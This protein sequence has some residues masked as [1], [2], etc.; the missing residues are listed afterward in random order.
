MALF[1]FCGAVAAL[2]ILPLASGTYRVGPGRVRLEPRVALHGSTVIALPPLGAVE[3]QTHLSPIRLRLSPETIDL[4]DVQRLLTRRSDPKRLVSRLEGE[5]NRALRDAALRM[6]AVG[7]GGGLLAFALLRGTR[8]GELA[9]SVVAGA[10][11]PIL[12]FAAALAGYHPEAFR[13]PILT[14][15]LTRAPEIVGPVEKIEQRLGAFRKQ[16]DA[17]G[18]SAFGI[19]RFLADQSPVPADAVRILHIS[20][21]HLNPVGFDVALQV[22]R[23][24]EVCAVFD[25][26]DILAQGT[27][28]EA[29][30]VGRIASFQVPYVF[31][32]G[33]HDSRS[34]EAAVAAQPNARVLDGKET[35]IEGLTVAGFGDPLFTPGGTGD[36]SRQ[37]E[38]KMRYAERVGEMIDELETEP[39]LVMVHDRLIAAEL[40]GRS[41]LVLAGHDHRWSNRLEKGT[42]TLVSGST[43][44]AG[45][46]ELT[47]SSDQPIAL[48]VLYFSR[49]TRRLIAWDR[50]E[51]QGP[52]GEFYLKRTTLRQP[53]RP[54][55]SRTGG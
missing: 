11:V 6:A 16:L 39:D 52:R 7:S 28:L 44:A 24:F 5:R 8:T 2:A 41:R 12:V 50:I 49:S 40:L 36:T 53:H 18:S 47:P 22:A 13:D 10:L 34:T 54:I 48:E 33:N 4:P 20:D 1:A 38:E 14:G 19:Y 31:V 26:G 46:H 32:R 15:A 43:G 9:A 17:L 42:R 23:Q 27:D 55:A 30:F 51:V 45:L 21:L 3:A 25:T 37:R 35:E 29:N